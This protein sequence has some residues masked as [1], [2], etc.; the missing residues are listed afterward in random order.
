MGDPPRFQ[1]LLPSGAAREGYAL[2]CSR[3]HYFLDMNIQSVNE[4]SQYSVVKS[5]P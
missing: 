3:Y 1:L 5:K 4:F 2:G